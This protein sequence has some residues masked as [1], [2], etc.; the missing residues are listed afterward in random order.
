MS[1]EELE[2]LLL[3][4]TKG[5]EELTC[6]SFDGKKVLQMLIPDDER[7]ID[8]AAW[9]VDENIATIDNIDGGI[10][11]LLLKLNHNNYEDCV[12]IT[13]SFLDFFNVYFVGCDLKVCHTIENIPCD[14][15][16]ET[17]NTQLENI[18]RIPIKFNLN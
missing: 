18:T 1:E 8:Y 12:L 2:K 4:R 6:R 7:V 14:E 16:F 9:N 13:L 10:G 3:E 15:L 17:I 5:L 11:G